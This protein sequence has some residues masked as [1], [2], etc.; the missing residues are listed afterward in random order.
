MESVVLHNVR[1]ISG[2][3]ID[4]VIEN[5]LIKHMEK[6][7]TG[8][9]ENI[10]D[11]SNIYVSSGWIDMHVHAYPNFRP[12]GDRI[13]EIGV[14]QGVHT[15]I[16]AG[17]CGA[18]HID[19]LFEN[20]KKSKTNLLAFLNLS[21]IGLKQT[22]ELSNIDWID[23]KKILSAIDTHKNGIIGLKV[24]MSG[25]VIGKSGIKPL[26]IA[27]EISGETSLPLMVHIG[28]SPPEIKDIL[29]LLK[30]DDIVTHFL[31]GK[32][33]N[34][35]DER[36]NP[37]PELTDAIN[38]GV[39]LDVGHGS[40][41][42]SFKVA[43]M[44]K[45]NNILFNTIS[46]DIYRENRLNGPVYSMAHVLSKFFHLGY[47]LKEIMDAVTIHAAKWLKNEELA[48]LRVGAPANLTLFAVKKTPT[49]LMDSEGNKR[50]AKKKIVAKGVFING[51]FFEC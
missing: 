22:D 6:A 36:G 4:M 28:S 50:L 9:G 25:S 3:R 13:D 11:C 7:G 40:K 10:I 34:L 39:H 16:D 49:T 14:K 29:S 15:V 43:E 17:S 19:H 31:H 23:R 37:I 27:R 47:S 1:L 8:R 48:E 5:G 44:A 51:E 32:Q 26:Q 38:R 45:E 24:R 21:R 20:V 30:K 42:F 18:D 2:K 35:F 33:N 46:T 41:S 12:Y